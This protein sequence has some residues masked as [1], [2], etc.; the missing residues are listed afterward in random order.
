MEADAPDKEL[1]STQLL[2]LLRQLKRLKEIS[3]SLITTY[4]DIALHSA[5]EQTSSFKDLANAAVN[6][7]M[8]M[9]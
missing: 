6:K 3:D 8:N 1:T 4:E 9:E 5:N 2:T 7:A